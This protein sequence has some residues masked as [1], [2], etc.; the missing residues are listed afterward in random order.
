[1]GGPQVAVKAIR[2][3]LHERPRPIDKSGLLHE[4]GTVS[5]Q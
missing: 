3:A 1:V 4:T 5:I 2:V